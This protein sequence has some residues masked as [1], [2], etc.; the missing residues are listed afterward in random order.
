MLLQLLILHYFYFEFNNQNIISQCRSYLRFRDDINVILLKNNYKEILYELKTNI[1][2]SN[3]VLE[4]V[5]QNEGKESIFLDMLLEIKLM[6][7]GYRIS[8][9]VY[10]KPLNLYSYTHFNSNHPEYMKRSIIIG[11]LNRYI[12]LSSHQ[13]DYTEIKK[14]FI[15]RLIDRGYHPA[16]IRKT[17]Q[18]QYKNRWTMISKINKKRCKKIKYILNNKNYLDLHKNDW[19]KQSNAKDHFLFIKY[20]ENTLDNEQKLKS[21]I[22]D[23]LDELP[24]DLRSKKNLLICNKVHPK[25]CKLIAPNNT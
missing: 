25:I 19:N 21:Y 5:I 17:K 1:F 9:K 4:E 10:Q 8:S 6:D 18:P 15:K 13:K 16:F 20:C 3:I 7:D 11:E 14:L 22:N 2:P 24:G 12:I 23:A